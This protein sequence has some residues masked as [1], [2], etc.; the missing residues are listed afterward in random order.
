MKPFLKNDL[1]AIG[2]CLLSIGVGFAVGLILG[3]YY[4]F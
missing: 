2:L 4:A 3:G 1:L